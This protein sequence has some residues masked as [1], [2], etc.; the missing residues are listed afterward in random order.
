M[1]TLPQDMTIHNVKSIQTELLDYIER[2]IAEDQSELILD[3]KKVDDIDAAGLEILLSAYLT[4]QEEGL[5]FKLKNNDGYFN[6]VLNLSG[7]GDVLD[8]RKGGS[9]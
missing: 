5:S 7:A 9:N 2:E 8:L 4:A 3:A 6:E 1:F